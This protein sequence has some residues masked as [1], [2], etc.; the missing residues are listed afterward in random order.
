MNVATPF[1]MIRQWWI[2]TFRRFSLMPF[3]FILIG[4]ELYFYING[5]AHFELWDSTYGQVIPV[6]ILMTVF[7]LIWAGTGTRREL[8]RPV[9]EAAPWFVVFFI[10]TYLVMLFA[11]L[12]GLFSPGVAP[13]S[14][15]WPTV[16]LQVCVVATAEE[17]M[18][19]GVILEVTRSVIISSIIFAGFHGWAYGMV[20]YAGVFNWGAVSFAFVM[21]VILALIYKRWGLPACISTHAAYNLVVSGILITGII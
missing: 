21:G 16:I 9:R 8:K 17:L 6:Y 18:F 3:I 5:N 2:T 10:G 20:Y 11:V 15:F 12:I 1:D 14:L 19:R 4:I 7:F 13:V